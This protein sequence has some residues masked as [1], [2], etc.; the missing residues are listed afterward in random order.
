MDKGNAA[1][2]AAM[3]AIATRPPPPLSAGVSHAVAQSVALG[4]SLA[5]IYPSEVRRAA[6]DEIT[7]R[8]MSVAQ[9]HR[10][11]IILLIR[12]DARSPA[13]ALARSVFEAC[14]RG[15]WAQ[16]AA[17]DEQ[18]ERIAQ[19]GIAPSFDVA[20][21][22][23]AKS[24]KA[25]VYAR[26]KDRIWEYLSDFAHGGPRQLKR[27]ATDS[28][29]EPV[30]SDAEVM[31]LLMHLDFLAVLFAVG[32]FAASGQPVEPLQQLLDDLRGRAGT[33]N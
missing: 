8:Y 28:A 25:P 3:T 29:I 16:F 24:Q 17:S 2:A 21:R 6:R 15:L 32:I 23:L 7:A 33:N 18:I 27:W 11:A 20:V 31:G 9:D 30:H 26:T 13:F 12:H 5:R 22:Q 1:S 19:K 10:D 4:D 14:M